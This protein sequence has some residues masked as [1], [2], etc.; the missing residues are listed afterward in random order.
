[1]KLS[2]PDVLRALPP[3]TV[4][5]VEAVVAEAE[6]RGVPIYLVGGPVR[7]VLLGRE[8]ADVDLIA[9]TKPECDAAELAQ[10]AAPAGAQVRVYDRFGT[11]SISTADASVDLAAVRRE[12]YRHP[13]A[14][15]KVEPGTLAEDLHRRDFS[16]NAMALRFTGEGPASRPNEIDVIDPEGGL[17]DL[18]RRRLRILHPRSFH[19]DPTRA[20]RAARLAP[21]LGFSLSRA[22]LSALRDALRDGVFGAVSGDRI[23]RELEKLFDDA[24]RGLDP[25]LAMRK[26]SDWHLLGA[27]EP[28][29]ELPRESI[30]P[31][32]RLGRS[33]ASPAWRGPRHRSWAA[34]LAVWLTPLAPGV[35]RRALRR[36]SVRGE[37]SARLLAFP[38]RLKGLL[39]PI[40]E[41]RGRGAV[42]ALLAGI[43]EE[44]LYAL[45]AWAPTPVRRRIV[46][47]AA[48]DR[49]R[50]APVGGADLAGL[51]LSGPAIGR[52]LSRIRS[53]YLDGAVANREEALALAAELARG[54]RTRRRAASKPR[55]AGRGRRR[56]SSESRPTRRTRRRR[57]PSSE[58]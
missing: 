37:L 35:R 42:D 27:L 33:I 38:S 40:A 52:A 51:G 32:R 9:E 8:I 54:A 25:A 7:D 20:L 13:G 18:E 17:Q 31:L 26:L 5:I 30:A 49:L 44:E 46:R 36:L 29:L 56:G 47:W 50:R 6:R 55:G 28:G 12:S 1:V 23:R 57:P 43:S 14:L 34:G 58:E 21:R 4:P 19:D 53:A 11:L 41:A 24:Q 3:A 2:L 22:S 45:H 16:V 48:E 39:T 15:P 10:A